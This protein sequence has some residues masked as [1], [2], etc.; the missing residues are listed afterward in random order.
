YMNTGY[1][2]IDEYATRNELYND[3]FDDSHKTTSVSDNMTYYLIWAKPYKKLDLDNGN[4]TCGNEMWKAFPTVPDGFMV[5]QEDSVWRDE[6]GERV[7]T[8]EGGKTYTFSGMIYLRPYGALWNYFLD[9]D[10]FTLTVKDGKDLKYEVDG[11][12]IIL[13]YKA[14]AGHDWD[15]G[16]VTK[17]PTETADGVKTFKCKHCDATKTEV[18]PKKGSKTN[19]PKVTT[20][21][22]T[23]ARAMTV[24][25]TMKWGKVN[26][27]K[28]YKV[29]YRKVGS[30]KWTYK[31]TKKT[32]YVVKGHKMKGLYEYKVAAVS[33]K[34]S[35]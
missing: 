14:T 25:W 20:T 5:D 7:R 8:F 23:S 27:A 21:A 3:V 22:K 24:K 35:T 32:Q 29:A 6:N 13:S 9:K 19:A 17:E 16:T 15:E 1:K 18:I 30:K 4:P 2:A 33:K 26:G 31:K 10:N 12:R 11:D 28:S 34:G